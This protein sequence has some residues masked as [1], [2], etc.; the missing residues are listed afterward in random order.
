MVRCASALLV[1]ITYHLYDQAI[2]FA[3]ER[4]IVG[5]VTPN[6]SAAWFHAKQKE[7][8]RIEAPISASWLEWGTATRDNW[9][10]LWARYDALRQSYEYRFHRMPPWQLE[11]RRLWM[12]GPRPRGPGYTPFPEEPC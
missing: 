5:H 3:M 1:G 4:G 8:P 9:S 11:V 12:V 7:L 10:W 6:D 2:A